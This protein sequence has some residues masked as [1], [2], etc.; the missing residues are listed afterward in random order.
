[1]ARVLTGG[2]GDTRWRSYAA[3]NSTEVV[4]L[5]NKVI[6]IGRLTADPEVKA[7]P[8]GVYVA[9]MRLATNTYS[10][11]DEEGNAKKQT[12]FHNLAVFGKSA[13][14]AGQY[15]RKGGQIYAEGRLKTTS[16]SDTAGLKHHRT[17]IVL[18]V[19]KALGSRAQ[20]AAA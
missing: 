18:D 15:L 11:K 10:G 3:V 13:E 16:W 19:L 9:N 20:E 2:V 7:T 5:I 14:F 12:E 6:L 1:V 8:G 4:R 17:E